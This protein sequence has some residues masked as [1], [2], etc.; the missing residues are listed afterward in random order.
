V[1]AHVQSFDTFV[2]HINDIVA[3]VRMEKFRLSNGQAVELS[4][5]NGTIAMPSQLGAVGKRCL[6]SL[7]CLQCCN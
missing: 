5:A 7:Y 2:S 3:N 1:Q 6:I 4:L